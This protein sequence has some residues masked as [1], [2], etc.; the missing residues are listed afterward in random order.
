M[1]GLLKSLEIHLKLP[2][3]IKVAICKASPIV[4]QVVILQVNRAASER[5]ETIAHLVVKMAIFE[6]EKFNCC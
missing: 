5:T 6:A 1:L 3:M 2:N 4:K